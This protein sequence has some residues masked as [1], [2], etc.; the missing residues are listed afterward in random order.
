MDR[1]KLQSYSVFDTT[2]SIEIN[3]ENFYETTDPNDNG[4]VVLKNDEIRR[5]ISRLHIMQD[6]N[7]L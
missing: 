7:P 1:I 4:C 2:S 6:Y 5:G 3:S